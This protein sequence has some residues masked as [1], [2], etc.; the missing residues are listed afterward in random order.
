MSIGPVK[1]TFG[2]RRW[3]L[4]VGRAPQRTAAFTLLEISLAVAILAMMSISIFRFVQTNLTAMRVAG[5]EQIDD[6]TYNGLIDLVTAQWQNL[7]SG[8]GALTGEPIKLN[9][10]NRDEITWTCGPGPGLLTRYASGEYTVGMR[11]RPAEKG[12]NVL[13]L[14]FVRTM[15]TAEGS[16]TA[17]SWVPLITGVLFIQVRYFDPRL[18]SWVDRWADTSRLPSLVK[19]I[20]GRPNHVVPFESIV[21]LNRTPF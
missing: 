11:V 8:V 21:A 2:V 14:G 12:S 7:P 9:D 18:N 16:E 19:V 10:I 13:Q 17:E 15:R 6:A 3:A 5:E 20:I 1:R 4:A